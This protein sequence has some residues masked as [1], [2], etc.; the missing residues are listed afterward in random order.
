MGEIDPEKLG[1]ALGLILLTLGAAFQGVRG[2][3]K[4]DGKPPEHRPLPPNEVKAALDGLRERIDSHADSLGDDVKDMQRSIDR[5]ERM[6]ERMAD[7]LDTDA[8]IGSAL[9][10][11]SRSE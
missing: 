3:K 7:R 1:G 5:L 10:R 2:A 9:A 4:S 11:I 8:R 6:I